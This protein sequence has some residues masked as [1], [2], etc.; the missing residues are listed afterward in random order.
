MGDEI[1]YNE[2][3]G[4][5]EGGKEQEVAEP[6]T[7]NGEGAG[8]AAQPAAGAPDTTGAGKDGAQGGKE[9][10]I[11]APAVENDTT[12]KTTAPQQT[13][14][15]KTPDSAQQTPEENAAF[16][17]A[18]RK[19]EQERDAAIAQAKEEAQKAID[20]AFANSGLTNPYTK[21][22]ITTK[23]EFDAYREQYEKERHDRILKKTG[24][25]D[26]EF[27]QYVDSMPE[28]QQ[29]RQA[30]QE[31]RAQQAQ[32]KVEEQLREISALD[33]SIKKLEDLTKMPNYTEFYARVQQGLSLTDAYK[34]T[35]YDALT[36]GAAAASRQATL[37]AAASKNHLGAT[38]SRGE[39]AVSVPADVMEQYRAFNP[40]ATDAEIQ[41][42]YNKYHRRS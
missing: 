15:A 7:G 16:A 6:A 5:D 27:K 36:K 3:F 20:E 30:A 1:N 23:A 8:E 29:A 42:H 32:M 14:P 9:Q 26:E 31:M 33:P 19:A 10:D 11:A 39:G 41:A 4:L 38:A 37:N 28:V 13:E 24:M 34:L 22:P 35:N 18:R 21:Q 25:T 40:D 2:L 12:K 17:A